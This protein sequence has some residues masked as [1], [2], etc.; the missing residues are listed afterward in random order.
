MPP[1][2]SRPAKLSLIIYSGTFDKVHYALATAAAATATNTPVTLFFTM[3]AIACL[4]R[5]TDGT[6][7]W[8]AVTADDGRRGAIV[9]AEFDTR[10]VG[11]FEELLQACVD[12]GA[13]FMVCDMGLRAKDIERA[14]LRDDVAFVEGGLVTFLNDARADGAMLFI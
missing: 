14:T 7:G 5:T 13:T 12:L 9:D 3:D 1:D 11:T 8:Q 10:G 2:A 6:P 4:T